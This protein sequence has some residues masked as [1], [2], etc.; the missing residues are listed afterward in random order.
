MQFML[1]FENITRA[2]LK[3]CL[4]I[5]EMIVFIVEPAQIGKAIGKKGANVQRLKSLLKDKE[6]KITEFH[7]NLLQFIKNLFYPV[8]IN[9]IEQKE[10][11]IEI[12][13]PD[14]KSRGLLIGRG[15]KNL[16]NNE[17]IVNRYFKI[18]EIKVV[19]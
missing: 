18:K 17:E 7:P 19:K 16:R 3:D 11:I 8:K 15:A 13:A 1:M 2:K 5:D 4:L 9:K 10:D 14:M 12:T 6:F